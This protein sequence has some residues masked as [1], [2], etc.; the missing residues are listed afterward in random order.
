MNDDGK[1]EVLLQFYCGYAPLYSSYSP[2]LTIYMYMSSVYSGRVHVTQTGGGA[3][4]Y[5]VYQNEVARWQKLEQ[6][7]LG[8]DFFI[9]R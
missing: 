8:C 6:A 7:F 2:C 1:H 9:V 4:S 5:Q 3:G